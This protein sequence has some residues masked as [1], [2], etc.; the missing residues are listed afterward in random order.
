M[1]KIF[2]RFLYLRG[3]Y[4][5]DNTYDIDRAILILETKLRKQKRITQIDILNNTISFITSSNFFIACLSNYIP[6]GRFKFIEL[7]KNILISYNFNLSRFWKV[8]LFVY[9]FLTLVL[10]LSS[11]K[12]ER[13]EL[14]IVSIL[15][16][17]V[18]FKLVC[19]IISS[20]IQYF[21]KN[22]YTQPSK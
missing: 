1:K 6:Y 18:S 20:S 5:I 12:S 8:F 14:S 13:I 11:D 7:N 17:F 15:L 16:F 2:E 3:N 22:L 21:L 10:L 19:V 9:F 4:L